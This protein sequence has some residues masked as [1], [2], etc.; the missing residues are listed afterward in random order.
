MKNTPEYQKAIQ[1]E[2]KREK[3]WRESKQGAFESSFVHIDFAKAEGC[4]NSPS[5]LSDDGVGVERVINKLDRKYNAKRERLIEETKA[6]RI[7]IARRRLVRNLPGLLDV[8]NLVIKNGTNRKE[9]IWEMISK[10]QM[11]GKLQKSNIGVT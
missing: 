9:S 7:K 6:K 2:K 5:W 3:E 1:D 4:E 11:S 10:K 8:F